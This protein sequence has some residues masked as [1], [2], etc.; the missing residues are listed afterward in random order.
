MDY[1]FD[2]RNYVISNYVAIGTQPANAKSCLKYFS[3]NQ[4]NFIEFFIVYH[5]FFFFFKYIIC[6]VD[7]IATY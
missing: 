5:L 7:I 3:K 4:K 6:E 2:E 1:V